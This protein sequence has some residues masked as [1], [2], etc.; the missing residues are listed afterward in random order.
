MSSEEK[1]VLV[2]V[3]IILNGQHARTSHAVAEEISFLLEETEMWEGEKVAVM[4]TEREWDSLAG[5]VL[6]IW[7]VSVK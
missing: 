3:R 7:L 6:T 5:N 2:E 4:R 1:P